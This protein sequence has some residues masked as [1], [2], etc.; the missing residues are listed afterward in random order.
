[1]HQRLSACRTSGGLCSLQCTTEIRCPLYLHRPTHH[2]AQLHQH[3]LPHPPVCSH[4]QALSA[5]GSL[6]VRLGM[7]CRHEEKYS[8]PLRRYLNLESI[9]WIAEQR[10]SEP[11]PPSLQEGSSA[12]SPPTSLA[13]GL[14]QSQGRHPLQQVL[15]TPRRRLHHTKSKPPRGSLPDAP[16]STP[17][18]DFR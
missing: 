2:Q 18:A 11:N 10:L 4:R 8:S 9:L 7:A 15:A 6:Q 5:N 3:H 17:P 13:R 16:L 12:S 14:S 1:M